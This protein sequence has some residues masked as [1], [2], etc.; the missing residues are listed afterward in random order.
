M[1]QLVK[2]TDRQAISS[3]MSKGKKLGASKTCKMM[4]SISIF[5]G[6]YIKSEEAF[7]AELLTYRGAR[8]H[9]CCGT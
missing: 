4:S 2:Q 1:E 5:V 7:K 6:V 9:W 8:Y 3:K